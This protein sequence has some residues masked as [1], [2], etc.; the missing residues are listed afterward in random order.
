MQTKN[1]IIAA[2]VLFC[3]SCSNKQNVS[4]ST[5]ED[6]NLAESGMDSSMLYNNFGITNADVPFYDNEIELVFSDDIDIYNTPNE[7]F[8]SLLLTNK[9]S[10]LSV[11]G[12]VDLYNGDETAHGK[13]AEKDLFRHHRVAEYME[14][15][16][17][18]YGMCEVC[19]FREK[20]YLKLIHK[21]YNRLLLEVDDRERKLLVKSQ[22][23]WLQSYEL[24]KDFAMSI[25][26]PFEHGSWFRL[27]NSCST[28]D[29]CRERFYFVLDKLLDNESINEIERSKK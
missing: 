7:Y 14:Y 4:E 16:L 18:T 12:I 8:D 1:Y 13:E 28:L 5:N 10:L 17:S 27:Q 23:I 11:Y 21:Y 3:V 6:F 26:E 2:I 15:D 24:D 19:G 20:S 9:D 22:N 29:K 25:Y